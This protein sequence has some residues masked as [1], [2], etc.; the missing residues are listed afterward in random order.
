VVRL[1][2]PDG[3][4]YR[5]VHIEAS[6]FNGSIDGLCFSDKQLGNISPSF[7]A[8]NYLGLSTPPHQKSWLD[9]LHYQRHLQLS[10]REHGKSE[11]FTRASPEWYALYNPNIRILIVSKT[12]ELSIRFLDVIEA[13]L[14]NEKIQTDFAD[15]VAAI[16]GRSKMR[17]GNKLWVNRTDNTIKEPTIECIGVGGAVTSGHFDLIICDDIVDDLNTRTKAT[18]E[19][20]EQWHSATVGGLLAPDASEHVI[21]TRKHPNDIYQ[22]LMDSGMWHVTIEQA[23]IKYP[24]Y[25]YISEVGKDGRE[26]VVDVAIRGDYKILW[27]DPAE[28]FAW[29][30]KKLLMKKREM[31]I[32][33]EREFQN[34]ASVMEGSLLKTDWL[35]YYT[36]NPD[37]VR[38][39][40]IM[41]PNNPK[42]SVQGWDFAIGTKTT[43]DYT[44]CCTLTVDAFNRCFAQFYR[45][46]IDFPTALDMIETLYLQHKPITVGMEDNQFQKGY[47]QSM[48]RRMIIPAVGVTQTKDKVTRIVAMTPF[49]Q[50]G[51][52]YVNIEDRD[53]FTEFSEFPTSSHDD[54]LDALEIALSLIRKRKKRSKRVQ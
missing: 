29:T 39:D 25:D 52:I 35:H 6:E 48:K 19:F 46:R 49:F 24:E 21:G 9:S 32:Y 36:T 4:P 10:P 8:W 44:V 34:N 5:G 17:I 33:F 1:R 23:I 7:Y 18:R 15:E 51:T 54:M 53:F 37:L 26:R 40:V 45:D 31:G 14:Q 41:F 28:K 38:D 20:I 42:H 50:N 2:K 13:D 12:H 22:T 27:E 16:G 43:N 11:T 30:I 3:G 47:I